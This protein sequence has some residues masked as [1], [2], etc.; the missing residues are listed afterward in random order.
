MVKLLYLFFELFYFISILTSILVLF[1]ISIKE[2]CWGCST[3]G[4]TCSTTTTGLTP[5]RSFICTIPPRCLHHHHHHHFTNNHFQ[6]L[7]FAFFSLPLSSPPSSSLSNTFC[8]YTCLWILCRYRFNYF[9]RF[10]G[11]LFCR[12]W[13]LPTTSINHQ[14]PLT[15]IY[16]L[17]AGIPSIGFQLL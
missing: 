6:Q 16:D 7:N 9:L 13:L 15:R 10:S 17:L 12:L 2:K 11:G 1:H 3:G 5:S 14:Q 4:D 8:R